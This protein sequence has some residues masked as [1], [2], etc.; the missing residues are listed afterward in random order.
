V[1]LLL[2]VTGVVRGGPSLVVGLLPFDKA[3]LGLAGGPIES[4]ALK[5]LDLRRVFPAFGEDGSCARLS[6]V[7]SDKDG[8]DFR[9]PV[10]GASR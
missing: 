5:K 9:T 2:G 6:T 1:R 4:P 8:R 10:C 3:E 7:L